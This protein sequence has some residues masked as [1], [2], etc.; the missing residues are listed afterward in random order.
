MTPQDYLAE[1]DARGYVEARFV[2]L[3][4]GWSRPSKLAVLKGLEEWTAT[5]LQAIDATHD[6]LLR[7]LLR[8][9]D[10]HRPGADEITHELAVARHQL[11]ELHATAAGLRRSLQ[12]GTP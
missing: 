6:P 8:L 7:R 9:D 3:Y 5:K 4:P 12:A 10:P 2:A 1:V 11:A